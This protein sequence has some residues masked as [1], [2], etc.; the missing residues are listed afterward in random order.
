[1]AAAADP[2]AALGLAPAPP[3]AGDDW[4]DFVGAIADIHLSR[5]AGP[6]SNAP[7]C[8]TSR[9][10]TAS[11][12]TPRPAAARASSSEILPAAI[13]RASASTELTLDPPDDAAHQGRV[14]L[15]DEDYL[16]LSTI[17]SAKGQEYELVRRA[18]R[19]RRLHAVRP[20]R[21]YQC[22][23]RDVNHVYAS[24]TRFDPDRLLHLFEKT[25]WPQA[26]TGAA[27]HS[28]SGGPRIDVGARMRGMW[29]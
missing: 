12:K 25:I 24:R 13:H 8:G 9:I 23:A 10:S 17:H 21:R 22:R 5:V 18:Q 1:M 11:T 3:R 7:G 28:A 27:A 16:V 15:L 2:I 29:R 20:R 14:P 6:T 4:T 26:P 19:G